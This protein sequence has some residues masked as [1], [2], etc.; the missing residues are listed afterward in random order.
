MLKV[1]N[2]DLDRLEESYSGLRETVLRFESAETPLC[3]RCSS[4]DTASVQV[5]LIGRTIA[6][7]TATS[8]V[9]LIPNQTDEGEWFCNHCEHYFADPE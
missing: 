9:R 4:A 5:G 6:L 1:T 8:K 2:E 7:A 3:P